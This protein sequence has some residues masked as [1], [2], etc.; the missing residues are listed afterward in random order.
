MV[1]DFNRVNPER[2]TVVEE[3]Q[4]GY[5]DLYDK[6]LAGIPKQQLP[7]LALAYPNQAAAYAA[8]GALVA[9]D[10][11]AHD[12]VWGYREEELA[13]FFPSALEADILPQFGGRYKL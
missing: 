6:I 7:A 13:D 9:L 8:Q 11:Y 12:S 4:G 2:I 5:T 10:S 1:E 3:S